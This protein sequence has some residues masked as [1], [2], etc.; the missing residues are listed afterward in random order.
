MS[1]EILTRKKLR[2]GWMRVTGVVQGR[3]VEF[4]VPISSIEDAPEAEAERFCK[5]SLERMAEKAPGERWD[6][7]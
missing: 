2:D 6:R 7:P 4:D 3:R 5:R 1:T